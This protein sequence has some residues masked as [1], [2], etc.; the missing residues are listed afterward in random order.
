MLTDY[1]PDERLPEYIAN[2]HP[3]QV[4]GT[5][6]YFSQGLND[7]MRYWFYYLNKHFGGDLIPFEWVPDFVGVS[8]VAVHK[9]ANKGQLTVLAY[10]IV[11]ETL[12]LTG[13]IKRKV[14]REVRYV[15]YEECVAWIWNRID[16]TGETVGEITYMSPKYVP[17]FWDQS[18]RDFEIEGREKIKAIKKD[19]REAHDV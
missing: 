8:R 6:I 3:E 16:F 1:P 14:V 10:R 15:P 2:H 13:K 11:E 7:E 18:L 9:R 5:R 12:S 17:G 19:L 4:E